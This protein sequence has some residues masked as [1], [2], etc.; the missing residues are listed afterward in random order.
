MKCD[1][2][3]AI[4]FEIKGMKLLNEELHKLIVDGMGRHMMMRLMEDCM[5]EKLNLHVHRMRNLHVLSLIQ[6]M[7]NLHVLSLNHLMRIL[8]SIHRLMSIH[9]LMSILHVLFKKYID[10]LLNFLQLIDYYLPDA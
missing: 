3:N 6:L 10:E 2:S 4:C 1:N 9:L 8:M 7:R 5:I